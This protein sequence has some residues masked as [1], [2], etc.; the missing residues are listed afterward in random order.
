MFIT[1]HS[2]YDPDTLQKEY[3]R[4]KDA[5]LPVHVPENYFPNDDDTRQPVVS[6]RSHA[7]LIY[8]NWLNYCVYQTTPFDLNAI[9]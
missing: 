2:E 7:N 1:G 3:L 5:G 4:D 8:Q 6:W 9:Q